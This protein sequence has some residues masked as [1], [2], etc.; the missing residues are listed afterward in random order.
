MGVDEGQEL[1]AAC[2]Q[3]VQRQAAQHAGAQQ[4]HDRRQHQ[5]GRA[6]AQDEAQ[7]TPLRR[8]G[9]AGQ[10]D[11]AGQVSVLIV[12]AISGASAAGKAERISF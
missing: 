12:H 8:V 11:L 4:G 10:L 6:E 1:A 9:Q 3:A 5:Q 2:A 7:P